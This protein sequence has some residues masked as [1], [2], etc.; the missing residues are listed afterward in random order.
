MKIV[1]NTVGMGLPKPNLMQT[2]PQKGDFVNGKEEFLKQF[3]RAVYPVKKTSDMVQ[4]VGV[5]EEGK[6]WARLASGCLHYADI[7]ASGASEVD[8]PLSVIRLADD[9]YVVTFGDKLITNDGY[10]YEVVELFIG[11]ETS[12]TASLVCALGGCTYDCVIAISNGMRPPN[13][14]ENV[15]YAVVSGSLM[16]AWEKANSGQKPNILLQYIGEYEGDVFNNFSEAVHV[17]HLRTWDGSSMCLYMDFIMAGELVQLS[18]NSNA[19]I[20]N[21]VITSSK[22]T[23]LSSDYDFL[24]RFETPIN[25]SLSE[26]GV[27]DDNLTIVSG[28]VAAMKLKLQKGEKVKVGILCHTYY[29]NTE[30]WGVQ[31]AYGVT[32]SSSGGFSGFFVSSGYYF[33]FYAYDDGVS[34]CYKMT[35][36]A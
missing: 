14:G 9:H 22:I 13:A 18:V 30:H 15:T 8:I 3:D 1:G 4:S 12:Y 32:V 36:L 6:L 29:W 21:N 27:T 34:N 25:T 28:N 23:V 33:G 17:E 35:S 7:A 16:A 11:S 2:D 20:T 19:D 31:E 5:D 26:Y 10:L 24:L